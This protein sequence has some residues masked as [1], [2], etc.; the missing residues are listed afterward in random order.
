MVYLG[1]QDDDEYG[2]DGY[3][4]SGYEHGYGGGYEEHGYG[5]APGG[6]EPAHAEPYGDDRYA[7]RGYTDPRGADVR[8]LGDA[9]ADSRTVAVRE[10]PGAAP[11]PGPSGAAPPS[12]GDSA[13][14]PLGRDDQPSGVTVSRPAVVRAV[15]TTAAKVHVI[16]PR[17]FNDAQEVGDRVKAN[18]AVILNLQASPKELRR[19]LID[20]SSGLAYAMGG[21]M[22]RVA[23]AVFLITPLNVQLSEEEK[24][25][26]EARGLY[27][28]D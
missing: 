15:P 13:V 8:P 23:D 28:R 20:F 26:L 2:Y 9:R 7:P 17:G 12:M 4:E 27:R 3:G 21:S 11:G 16:E 5:A 10:H 18:Q 6:H 19:R 22:S 25:R 14:R 24:D 1:L